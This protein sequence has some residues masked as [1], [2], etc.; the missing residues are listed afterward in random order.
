MQRRF[1]LV[2]FGGEA[3]SDAVCCDGLCPGA[4]L[5]LS[6]WR[7]NRTPR[8][9]KA[10]TS[11]EMAL[12]WAARGERGSAL[13]VNNH[14]DTDGVLSVWA[15]LEPERALPHA[16]ILAAAAEVGDFDEWP[17]DERGL[18]LEAAVSALAEGAEDD[19]ASYRRV[20]PALGDV[21]AHL[22]ARRELWGGAWEALQEA[23]RR[24]RQGAVAAAR[25]GEVAVLAHGAGEAELPGPVLTRMAPAG[26]KRWLVAFDAGGGRWRFRYE[27]P[28]YAWAETVRRPAIAS[29]GGERVATALGSGWSAK[30]GGM[31]AV[32]FTPTPIVAD[33]EAVAAAIAVAEAT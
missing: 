11:T 28:R 20:L 33:P 18:W 12:G 4:A 14:F 10:D 24:A 3:P 27:L 26:T 17:D 25:V 8:E 29:V 2:S 9:L 31:T 19:E 15:L 6:H 22:E 16:A 7:G 13:V 30:G 21:V 32:A 5:D 23:D 1:E